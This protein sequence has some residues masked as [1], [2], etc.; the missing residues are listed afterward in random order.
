[1]FWCQQC[2]GYLEWEDCKATFKIKYYICV[3]IVLAEH[4]YRNISHSIS[5]LL[6]V[7]HLCILSKKKTQLN[8]HT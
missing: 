6:L 1:M 4:S 3:G 7:G 2:T 5:L 8:M